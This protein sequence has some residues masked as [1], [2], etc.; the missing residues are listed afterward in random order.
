M[1]AEKHAAESP[2]NQRRNKK[3]N[4]NMHRNQWK[5]KQNNPKHM[6]HCKSSAKGKIHSNTGLPRETRTKSNK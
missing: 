5:W 1:E 4:Q 6:G 2:T 3:I